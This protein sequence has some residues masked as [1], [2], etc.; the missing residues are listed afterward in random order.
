MSYL[1]GVLLLL[2]N[3]SATPTDIMELLNDVMV[4]ADCGEFVEYMK[5]IYFAAKRK[6]TDDGYMEYLDIVEAE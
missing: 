4:S 1:K 5:L 3:C 6:V 2:K